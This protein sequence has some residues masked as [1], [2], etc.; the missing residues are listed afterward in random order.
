MS[1]SEFHADTRLTAAGPGAF[2]VDVSAR[3]SV[4]PGANGGYLAGLLA[5]GL[6]AATDRNDLRSLTAHCLLPGTPGPAKLGTSVLRAGRSATII[7]AELRRDDSMLA[8]A[9]GVLAARRE[10][11]NWNTRSAPDFP[12]PETLERERWPDPNMIRSRYDTR[13]VVGSFPAVQGPVAEVSGWL[14]P[15]DH[16][17]IDLPFLVAMCDAWPPPLLMLEGPSLMARTIDLT[18]HLFDMLETP[19]DGWVAMT[20][21]STISVDGY[22]DTET[23]AWSQDGRLL[24]QGRQLSACM[25]WDPPTS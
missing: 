13:Y 9:R 8:V 14:R 10:S 22:V 1:E 20:N 5:K 12:D 17:P 25:P 15:G 18:V 7:D 3:W 11:P 24:A 21:R 19:L 4:G 16:S 2:D 23:E 6:M